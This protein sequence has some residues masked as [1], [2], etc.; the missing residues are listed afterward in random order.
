VLIVDDDLA[1]RR[2][3][4]RILEADGN[5]V[6]A[7][8]SL[9]EARAMT[10]AKATIPAAVLDIELLDGCG[11]TLAT[12]LLASGAVSALV[13]FTGTCLMKHLKAAEA[14]A[15]VLAKATSALEVRE[16]VRQM[17]GVH[18]LQR[19]PEEQVAPSPR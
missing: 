1:V 6:L 18:F 8:A 9:A 5:S 19:R 15:P 12:E 16:R 4:R 11:V 17:V 2:S 7:A 13:F 14:V 3:L 10:A